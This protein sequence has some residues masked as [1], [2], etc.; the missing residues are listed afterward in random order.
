MIDQIEQAAE[1]EHREVLLFEKWRETSPRLV[2]DGVVSASDFLKA[3]KKIVYVLKEV[4]DP[5]GGGWDLRNVALRA[6]RGYTWNNLA[7]WSSAIFELPSETDWSSIGA[8]PTTLRQKIIRSIAVMNIKKDAGGGS[9][10]WAEIKLWAREYGQTLREQL[11]IYPADLIVACGTAGLVKNHIYP[12]VQEK[13]SVTTRGVQY[14]KCPNGKI[15]IDYWHPG[16]RY[17]GIFLAYSLVD[18]VSEILE[19]GTKPALS[20]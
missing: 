9:S 7:R 4:N 19:I 13:W 15:L 10:I 12:D 16:A 11:D 14:L 17:P 1:I 3:P 20:Q 5:G 18:A 2:S 8:M 6:D